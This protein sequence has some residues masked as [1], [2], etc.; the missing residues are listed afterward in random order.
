MITIVMG[1]KMPYK[2]AKRRLMAAFEKM[3]FGELIERTSG[4]LSA[5]SREAKLSRRHVRSLLQRHDLYTP[6]RNDADMAD[7]PGLMEEEAIG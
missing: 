3:Y 7:L 2:V 1:E 4:N 5:A 6:P